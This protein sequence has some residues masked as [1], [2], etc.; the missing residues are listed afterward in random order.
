M[1]LKEDGKDVDSEISDCDDQLN[2]DEKFPNNQVGFSVIPIMPINSK[3][4]MIATSSNLTSSSSSFSKPV[5]WG[6]SHPPKAVAAS[7]NSSDAFGN[8][9]GFNMTKNKNVVTA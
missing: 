7:K 5:T 1:K 9:G 2:L 3:N 6:G 8:G 4:K